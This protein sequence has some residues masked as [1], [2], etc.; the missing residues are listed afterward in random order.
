[1]LEPSKDKVD[2]E[3]DMDV[4]NSVRIGVKVVDAHETVIEDL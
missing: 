4:R 3:V 1:M 2:H